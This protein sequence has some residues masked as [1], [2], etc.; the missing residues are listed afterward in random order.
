M[1]T[2]ANVEI[3]WQEICRRAGSYPI[4]AFHFVR[5]GLSYTVQ[6]NEKHHAHLSECERHVSGQE[7]CEA[8][9]LYALDQFGY[10]AKC[11]LNNWGVHSTSDF[12]AIVFNM[13]EIG[14][15][16]KTEH[17]RR[18]DFDDVP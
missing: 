10:M 6:C 14:Q 7:L 5:D 12:G 11:V 9:R 8:I 13:I 17:D 1:T 15:M 4:E 3:D 16:R 18:E 2:P